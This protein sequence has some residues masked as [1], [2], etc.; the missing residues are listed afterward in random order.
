MAAEENTAGGL[1]M[2]KMTFHILVVV[3]IASMACILGIL[4]LGSNINFISAQYEQNISK[5]VQ[6]QKTM[7]SIRGEIYQTESLVWQHIVSGIDTEYSQYEERIEELLEDIS[8][9]FAR[10]EENLSED[11]DGEMLHI[12]VRQFVG[13]KSNTA[14][15]LDLSRKGAK[16]SAQYYVEIKL[17]PYFDNVNETLEE[18]NQNVEEKGQ[19]ATAKMEESIASA[20]RVAVYCLLMAGFI[21]V[22]CIGIVFWRGRLIV[23]RQQEELK[24]HQQRVMEL[25]YNTIVG[26]ANLIESRDEDTGEHVKRTGWF[27]DRIARRLAKDS[28]YK[29]QMDD[30]FLENLWKAAPLHDIGK[31]KI[32]D[33]ILQK[34]G[35]LTPEEFE[36]IKSHAAEGGK[37]VY[38]TLRGIEEWDYINMAHDV[39]KYHHEK[40]NGTGYPEGLAGEEIPLCARIMAVA[41]V[42]DALISK[43][44]YKPAMTV[45][46]AYGI[47]EESSGSHF[48]PVVAKVFMDLRP[49]VERY[50]SEHFEK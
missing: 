38:E 1:G 18:I 11:S 46:E 32:P 3:I 26:M 50:L 13:F 40:W 29:E 28:I 17:N 31:I 49:E 14:A 30:T 16:Q 7:A 21:T 43:R 45:E 20:R 22:V 34:P 12:I 39:A 25:Q 23:D 44:C 9:L 19:T 27:V 24:N 8:E 37:I 41:D 35:K 2:R 36:I 4:L 42:F 10:L 5:A 48:D 47:I 6:N 15:V 33:A